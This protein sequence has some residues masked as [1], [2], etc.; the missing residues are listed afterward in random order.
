MLPTHLGAQ[1]GDMIWGD[2][3]Q[4]MTR[5]HRDILKVKGLDGTNVGPQNV[6][7]SIDCLW[8][9]TSVTQ[10]PTLTRFAHEPPPSRV[11]TKRYN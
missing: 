3:T 5:I 2:P 4:I 1:Q 6:I 11:L 8:A 7:P 10:T 9:F